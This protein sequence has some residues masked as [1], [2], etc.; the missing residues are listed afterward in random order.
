MENI[1]IIRLSPEE[2]PAY[3]QIRLEAL[4]SEPQ[5]FSSTYDET[6]Q[7]PDSHWQQRLRDVQDGEN[8]WLLFARENDRLIGLIGAMRDPDRHGYVDIISVYVAR[9]RRGMGV[10]K[11]LMEAI[12]A[13]VSRTGVYQ[14]AALSV[15]AEQAA[16][17]ALYR[18]F[19]FE[20]AAEVTDRMG[21]GHICRSY[22]MEKSLE[23]AAR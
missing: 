13:E 23:Q 11:A 22:L 8:S 5:A 20:V 10:G 18:R 21:D 9:D 6:R 1:E 4:H 17:V 19:G 14:A 12:L 7:R 15:N 16:A 2:W 3:R